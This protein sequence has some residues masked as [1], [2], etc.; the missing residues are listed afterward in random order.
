MVAA[1]TNSKPLSILRRLAFEDLRNRYPAVPE[2]AIPKP[3]YNDHTANGLTKCIIDFIQL[4]GGQA[5]RI[6]CTGRI[7]DC[8]K[9]HIDVV[10]FHR[11]IGS[12]TWIP[13]SMQPGTADI[14]GVYRGISIKVEVKVGRDQQSLSQVTYQHQVESAGGLYFVAQDFDSFYNWFNHIFKT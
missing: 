5:E 4:K 2:Y 12:V 1:K 9:K 14:S 11:T 10:G 13:S 3:K 6:S 7:L 8:R